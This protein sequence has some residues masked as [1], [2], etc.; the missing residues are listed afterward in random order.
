MMNKIKK[1]FSLI[2]ALVFALCCFAPAFAADKKIY[3]SLGDSIAYG[4]GVAN[5]KEASFG[6]IVADTI[7]YDYVNQ[8]V[9]GYNS[10]AL[11]VHL[12]LPSVKSDIKRA[13]LI[14]LSIGG[15]DFLTD[16]MAS[17]AIK[18]I[19]FGDYSDFDK[20]AEDFYENFCIIIAKIK[21]YN[22]DAVLLVNNLYNPRM[23]IGREI[24]QQGVDRLNACYKRY[25]EENPGSYA[26]VDAATA[27]GDNE[28]YIAMDTIHPSAQGNVQI[29]K[30]ALK[31]LN[32]LGV[33]QKTELVI[34]ATGLD[35]GANG[36]DNVV[37]NIRKFLESLAE[38]VFGMM[39]FNV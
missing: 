19:V 36:F 22:P 12:E 20:I 2:L 34:N 39:G 30:A 21:E 1:I 28:A 4:Q 13:D 6:K 16:N 33:T 26:M 15:N 23:G 5:P 32:N 7:G 25:L 37:N 10:E 24:Y 9:S 18:A 27:I 11:L 29:A 35:Y 17:L 31:T 8:A 38:S 3:L 14:N